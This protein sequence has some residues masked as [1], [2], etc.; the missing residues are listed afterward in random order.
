MT[1]PGGLP[2]PR[3]DQGY[4]PTGAPMAPGS[5]SIV[6]ARQVIVFGPDG[7]VVGIFVYAVGTTP[8]PGNPPVDSITRSST[9]PFG[10]PVQ[11]DLVAY[12]GGGGYAQLTDGLLNFQPGGS[13]Q[14]AP[15]TVRT[16]NT[17]GFLDL[18]SGQET[19]GDV[20][21]EIT[22]Q[23]QT[24]ADVT[25]GQI[26]FAAGQFVFNGET[27]FGGMVNIPAGDGPFI[28]GETFH[29]ISNG[30]GFIAR[31]K[32]LPW[33]A[34]WLDVQASWS[35]TGTTNLASLPSSSY[36]PTS[37]RQFP[38]ASTGASAQNARVFVPTSGA[39]QVVVSGNSVA[40]SGGISMM[41]PTVD[42]THGM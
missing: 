18:F 20:G 16:L 33:N 35:G 2:T 40:G 21:S 7:S 3:P 30:T 8:G 6:R 24:A 32:L 42:V 22:L 29:D 28:A 17:P 1:M 12:G 23:S 19:S 25:G 26:I 41:Y 31:V 37:T 39:L 5:S 14:F 9:D 4:S 27:Q 15:G 11:P 13:L 38:L 10:N 36:Y 34:V